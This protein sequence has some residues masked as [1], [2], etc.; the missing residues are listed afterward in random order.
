ML[1]IVNI[2]SLKM[3]FSKCHHRSHEYL[4]WIL[5]LTVRLKSAIVWK[6]RWV[7]NK[8]FLLC[9]IWIAA[10]SKLYSKCI[11]FFWNKIALDLTNQIKSDFFSLWNSQYGLTQYKKRHVLFTA[12][13]WKVTPKACN[14][15]CTVGY[16][17][18]HLRMVCYGRTGDSSAFLWVFDHLLVRVY[19]CTLR[20]LPE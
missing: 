12:P 9:A 14:M 10:Q 17:Y 1:S 11:F 5:V 13:C 6:T 7:K 8:I 18:A 16:T 20:L 3:T 19:S 15:L 4:R 2:H